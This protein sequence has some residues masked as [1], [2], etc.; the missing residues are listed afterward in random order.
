MA[1]KPKIVSTVDISVEE[2]GIQRTG[3]YIEYDDGTVT[4]IS[5][6]GRE[7]TIQIGKS[8]VETVAK[9]HCQALVYLP[10]AAGSQLFGRGP[11]ELLM[12]R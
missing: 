4:V 10:N 5:D 9:M 11:S 6:E 3:R 8:D 12:S 7:K 2:D 1:R